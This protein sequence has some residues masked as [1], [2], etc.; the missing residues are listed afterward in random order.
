MGSILQ[1]RLELFV[2]GL[3][4]IVRVRAFA[5]EA[6]VGRPRAV[7]ALLLLMRLN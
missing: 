1:F 2:A 5:I 3:P 7:V 6:P 4:S